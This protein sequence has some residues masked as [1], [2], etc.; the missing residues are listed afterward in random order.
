[1]NKLL[2]KWYLGLIL[3][4]FII[5]LLTNTIGLPD[6]FKNWTITLLATLLFIIIILVTKLI[7]FSKK[8]RAFEFKPKESDKRIVKRLI[9]TLD[10][11][12][13][14]REVMEQDS[15][16]GYKQDAIGKTL[17]FVEECELLSN[18]TSDKKLNKLILNTKN[19]IEEFNSYSATQLCGGKENWYTLAK[20]TS[21][22]IESAKKARPIMN[23]QTDIAFAKLTILLDYLKYRNYFE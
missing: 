22:N 4:P 12:I 2:N 18:R 11:N 15:W 9:T 6:L 19:A 21:F 3:I 23:S 7:E 13:F 20:D 5:N 17:E 8:I 14:H 1:M 10:I 16:Y